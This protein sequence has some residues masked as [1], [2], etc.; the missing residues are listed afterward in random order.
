M[1]TASIGASAIVPHPYSDTPL[2]LVNL[3]DNALYTAKKSGKNRVCS[4]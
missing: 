3:A 4:L 1:I 2:S